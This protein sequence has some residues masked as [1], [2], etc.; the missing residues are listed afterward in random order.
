MN[1]QITKKQSNTKKINKDNFNLTALIKLQNSM[2]Q[3]CHFV[4]DINFLDAW[5]I[6]SNSIVNNISDDEIL[7]LFLM[8]NSHKIPLENTAEFKDFEDFLD[9][10]VNFVNYRSSQ[11]LSSN[12]IMPMMFDINYQSTDLFQTE[13]FI[14]NS[15]QWLYGYLNAYLLINNSDDYINCYENNIDNINHNDLEKTH[16]S[17]QLLEKLFFDSLYKLC[18]L[19]LYLDK[20]LT[21]RNQEQLFT[22]HDD[23]A[24]IHNNTIEDIYSMWSYDDAS[25]SNLD[26][27]EHEINKLDKHITFENLTDNLKYF[28][29][30]IISNINKVFDATINL[31]Q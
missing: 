8:L 7:P 27:L 15:Y 9:Q 18:I 29:E 5:I 4:Y 3:Y 12:K 21:T 20:H 11:I 31:N 17:T 22:L 2:Q 1:K 13:N 28:Q 24:A 23:L 6:A 16:T 30:M 14:I 10:L 25:K 19:F 26:T